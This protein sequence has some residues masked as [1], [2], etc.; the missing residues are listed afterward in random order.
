MTPL[1]KFNTQPEKQRKAV[2]DK[3]REWSVENVDWW[4]CV[5]ETFKSDMEAIGVRVRK[6]LFSGF[7]SQG[8]GACFD[9][10]VE[11]WPL[12]LTSIGYSDAALIYAAENFEWGFSSMHS[13]YLYY[14]HK[15]VTY[16]G[17]VNLPDNVDDHYFADRYI[18]W[19][20][21]D[22][23]TATLMTNLSNYA[24]MAL[25]DE[26]ANVFE[27]YMLDLYKQLHEEY[28]HLTSDESVLD[29]LDINDHLEEAIETVTEKDHA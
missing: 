6:I 24:P 2:L 11:D 27:N 19:G 26:F 18:E 25:H 10:E 20:P 21:D 5:E 7:W 22:I 28:D 8:D 4:D 15:S 12:F 16:G 13:H 9:G 3:Y 29:S 17:Q 1:Q 23:R 14:H